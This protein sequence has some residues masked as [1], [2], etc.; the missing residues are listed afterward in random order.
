MNGTGTEQRNS[1]GTVP[2]VPL[3]AKALEN[4]TME[5]PLSIEGEF[6]SFR[7]IAGVVLFL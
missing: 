2:F 1:S 4:G 5:H 6:R 3:G 7:S